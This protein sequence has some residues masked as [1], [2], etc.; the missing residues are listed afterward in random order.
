MPRAS[1][2][3]A[4][5]LIVALVGMPWP[6]QAQPQTFTLETDLEYDKYVKDTTF[7]TP[8]ALGDVIVKHT[9]LTQQVRGLSWKSS[10]LV[11]LECV[12]CRARRQHRKGCSVR[13]LV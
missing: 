6:G 11:C 8:K 10:T 7:S 2:V 5:M 9:K 12:L 4:M 3:A 13:N 1:M